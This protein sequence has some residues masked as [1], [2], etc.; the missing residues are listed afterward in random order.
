MLLSFGVNVN[1]EARHGIMAV[2]VA[3]F[4]GEALVVRQ[5]VQKGANSEANARWV[6]SEDDFEHELDDSDVQ[7]SM[8]DLLHPTS[9]TAEVRHEYTAPQFAASRGH[10][11]VV[12]MLT[13]TDV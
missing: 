3:A 10:G 6:E 12:E 1:A 4:I 7:K 11:Q 5:L 13:F 9:F 8:Y 2:H